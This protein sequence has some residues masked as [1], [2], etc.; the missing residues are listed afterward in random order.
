MAYKLEVLRRN[1]NTLEDEWVVEWADEPL[2]VCL[3]DF[4]YQKGQGDAVMGVRVT[5]E[6]PPDG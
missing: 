4:F 6:R 1:S 5:W 3:E 2:D